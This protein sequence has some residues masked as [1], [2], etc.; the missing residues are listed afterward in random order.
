MRSYQ[1]ATCRCRR[2]RRSGQGSSPLSSMRA[3]PLAASVSYT[4]ASVSWKKPRANFLWLRKFPGFGADALHDSR[5]R[6]A[7]VC[8]EGGAGLSPCVR[9]T[10]REAISR[11][12]SSSQHAGHAARRNRTRSAAGTFSG[13]RQ[14]S[15]RICHQKCGCRLSPTTSA[16]SAPRDRACSSTS[17]SQRAP[18]EAP[19]CGSYLVARA[20]SSQG[21]NFRRTGDILSPIERQ[22][23]PPPRRH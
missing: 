18:P 2:T 16:V 20:I 8:H 7:R 13:H 4:T 12:T 21:E 22:G 5:C 19:T 15:R 9:N 14:R 6:A 23:G 11:D 3:M 1:Q 17:R 10:I